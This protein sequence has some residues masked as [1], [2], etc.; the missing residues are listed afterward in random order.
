MKIFVKNLNRDPN[1]SKCCGT[2]IAHWK[3]YKGPHYS[4]CR[5]CGKRSSDL[6]GGHVIKVGNGTDDQWYIVPLCHSCNGIVDG[7]FHVEVSDLVWVRA[8]EE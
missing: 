3:K 7:V 1:N 6:V 4:L 8:C 5:G 2:W